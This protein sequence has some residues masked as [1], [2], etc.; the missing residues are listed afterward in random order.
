MD[1]SIVVPC[2][3]EAKNLPSLLARFREALRGRAGVEVILVNNGSTDDSASVL[4]AELARPE[5]AFARGVTVPVNQGYGFGITSGLR[6]ARGA[7][8]AWTHA[9]LQCD[10]G[11][12]LRGFERLRR[13]PDPEGCFLRGRRRGRKILDTV[14]T[15][16][17]SLL[18]SMVLHTRLNDVNAQPKIFHRSFFERMLNPPK[19]F[20]LDLY[21]LY[22]A[23]REGLKVLSQRVY[24]GKR[25]AGEAKGGGSLRGKLRLTNRTV[26]YIFALRRELRRAS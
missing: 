17:M 23:R 8:L 22:L 24:F 14:F 15:A 3:N 19:D 5:H 1:L 13:E 4:A 9:D 7:F 25:H 10:P 12:V 21:A 26:R 6:A 2:Y 16:G 20:S 11:D 18:A